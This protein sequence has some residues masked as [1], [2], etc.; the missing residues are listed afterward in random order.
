MI[1]F[2]DSQILHAKYVAML[3]RDAS[4]QLR[5]TATVAQA[6]TSISGQITVI[7]DLHGKL[8]D[9]LTILYKV[10]NLNS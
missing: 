1:S 3:L 8:D 7:G 10:S 4:K 2:Q 9:L 5:K 6:S